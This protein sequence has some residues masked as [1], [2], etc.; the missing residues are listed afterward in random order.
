MRPYNHAILST[1]TTVTTV[2]DMARSTRKK[3]NQSSRKNPLRRNPRKAKRKRHLPTTAR[4]L[5]KKRTANPKK[6][7]SRRTTRFPTRA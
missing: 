1:N 2:K 5:L 7:A 6:K 4:T 3:R